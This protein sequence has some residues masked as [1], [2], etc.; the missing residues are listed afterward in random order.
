MLV[1]I[2]YN[3]KEIDKEIHFRPQTIIDGMKIGI[4]KEKLNKKGV[5][6]KLEVN[7]EK[8]TIEKMS[9]QQKDLID[10]LC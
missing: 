10:L 2:K 8:Q 5:P 3:D 6:I 4:I 7:A 9:I 1:Y